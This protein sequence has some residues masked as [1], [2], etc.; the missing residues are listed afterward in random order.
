[1]N[2]YEQWLEAK[3]IETKAQARRRELEEELDALVGNFGEGTKTLV[4]QGYKIVA[5]Q[6]YNRKVDAD[7]VQVLASELGQEK[8][9][10][11]LFRWK[12]EVNLPQW[13][14]LDSEIAEYLSSAIT[15]KPGKVSYKIEKEAK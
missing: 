15:T 7:K 9:L 11:T 13:K 1:M 2:L 3:E 6:R 8:L 12:P 5:T 10:Q 4:D 14:G